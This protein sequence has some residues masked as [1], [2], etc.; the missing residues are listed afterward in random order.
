MWWMWVLVLAILL[1]AVV[2]VLQRRGST[3]TVNRSDVPA[4]RRV[5]QPGSGPDTAPGAGFGGLG[6]M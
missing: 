4:D 6:G 5:D 2:V 3:G 1:V